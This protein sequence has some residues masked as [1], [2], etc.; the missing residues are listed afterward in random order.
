M[1]GP[2]RLVDDPALHVD[3]VD[4]VRKSAE[5]A[6]GRLVHTIH[7]DRHFHILLPDQESGVG[8]FFLHARGLLVSPEA[9]LPRYLNQ[10]L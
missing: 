2:H 4:H 6:M 8:E 3:N 5:S 1:A 7:Q 10:L 9:R